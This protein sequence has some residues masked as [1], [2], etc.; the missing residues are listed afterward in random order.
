M[1]VLIVDDSAT[2]RLIVKSIAS[3]HAAV[4]EVYEVTD[5]LKALDILKEKSITLVFS[6]INMEPIS[7]FELIEKAKELDPDLIPLFAFMTSH[8]TEAMQEKAKSVGGK[9][10]ITKPITQEKIESILEQVHN[11]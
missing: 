3:N 1:N 11:G 6:D 8:L 9:F 5:G 7:G 2:Q 4:S 10:Y